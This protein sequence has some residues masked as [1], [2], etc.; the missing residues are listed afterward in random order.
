M[1]KAAILSITAF[2][3]LLT[4]GMF[5]CLVHCSAESIVGEPAMEMASMHHHGH[6]KGDKDCDCCKKHG[7]FVIKENLKPG[8]DV[9]F[10]QVAVL[11]P[12]NSFAY[13]IFNTPIH[14]YAAWND[15]DP[16]AVKSGRTRLIQLRSLLI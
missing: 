4:T 13:F 14:S 16:P 6:S 9:Q 5:V 15:K 8:Y 11:I 2:Y 12:H 3:L 1:K 10:S 7:N